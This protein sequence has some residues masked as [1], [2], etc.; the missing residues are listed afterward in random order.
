[1]KAFSKDEISVPS[2]QTSNC[3]STS[4]HSNKDDQEMGSNAMSDEGEVLNNSAFFRFPFQMDLNLVR[5]VRND[6][7]FQLS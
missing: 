6:Q 7:T 5:A 3:T 4:D 2:A 1:M